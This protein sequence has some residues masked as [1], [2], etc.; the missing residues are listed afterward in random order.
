MSGGK[1]VKTGEG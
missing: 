1:K